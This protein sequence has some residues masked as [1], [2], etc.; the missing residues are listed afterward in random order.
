MHTQKLATTPRADSPR[1]RRNTARIL[2]SVL[3]LALTAC[4]GSAEEDADGNPGSQTSATPVPDGVLTKAAAKRVVDAYEKTNNQA[5]KIQDEGLL[6]TVEGGQLHEQS[7]ADY[8]AFDTWPKADQ[9]AYRTAFVYEDREYLIPRQSPNTTWFAVQA[10]S[11]Y[12]NGT[13]TLL[14]FDKVGSTYKMVMSLYTDNDDALPQIARDRH[15][16]AEAVDPSQ[17]IGQIT[18]TELTAAFQ[19]LYETGGQ[20][21]GKEL[22]S[23]DVT[24]AALKTYRTS[25]KSGAAN[26]MAT[27]KFFAE[28]P[29]HA[30]VYALRTAS[31]GVLAAFPA[32][33]TRETLLKPAYR[34]SH[35]LVPTD[36]QKALGVGLGQTALLTDEFQ[37]QGLAILSQAS[38]RIAEMD[39]QHVDAR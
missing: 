19:D 22:A 32:A 3:L 6:A 28:E 27:V 13:R 38:A 10:K 7:K 17:Q 29:A 30:K 15:G 25:E 36:R 11:S 9:N 37:G 34:S 5:N 39:L 1:L 24:K 21:E 20:G 33:H 31:G 35:H 18:P 12:G 14:F 23:T 16:L 2:A 4:G 8:A 26:G